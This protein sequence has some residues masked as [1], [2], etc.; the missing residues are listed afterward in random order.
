[1][2]FDIY[3]AEESVFIDHHEESLFELVNGDSN[4]PQLNWIWEKFYDGPVIQ[5]NIA[6]DLVHELILLR[7]SIIKSKEH[8]Y[9]SVPIDRIMPLLSKAYKNDQQLKCMSD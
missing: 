8:L 1:M 5:P 2:P 9:L 6:N 7:K 4:F 3:L